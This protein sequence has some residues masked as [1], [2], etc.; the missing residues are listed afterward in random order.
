MRQLVREATREYRCVI[1]DSPPLL[2][3]ADSRILATMVEGLI[4]VVEGGA[5]PRDLA[6]R[7]QACVRHVGAAVI[8][9][10][11]N[12]LDLRADGGY[13]YGYYRDDYYGAAPE[14]PKTNGDGA[15]AQ[16]AHAGKST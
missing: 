1:I 9:V 14:D 5:T 12:N 6:Q 15:A 3:V 16:A 8:G 7:A 11:L 4:L 10:V 13:S 2:N